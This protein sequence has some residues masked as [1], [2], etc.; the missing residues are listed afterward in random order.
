MQHPAIPDPSVLLRVFQIIAVAL[1]PAWYSISACY[2]SFS[3][4][5]PPTS[6][7]LRI[8]QLTL[9]SLGILSSVA[10]SVIAAKISDPYST[11]DPDLL[12]ALFHTLVWVIL[13]FGLIDA[14]STT[15]YPHCGAWAILLVSQSVILAC[16]AA[17]ISKSKNLLAS[18][19]IFQGIQLGLVGTLF[20]SAVILPFARHKQLNNG[21]DDDDEQQPLLA[22]ETDPSKPKKGDQDKE[23]DQEE[24]DRLKI[25][26]R[27]GWQY[28]ASFKLFV[29][30]M[31]P[32]S[33][34]QR[35]FLGGMIICSALTRIVTVGL[36]LSLGAVVNRLDREIPWAAIALY[37]FL[38]FLI[39]PAG[40]SLVESWFTYEVTTDMVIALNRHCYD[41]IM[42]LSADFH[43]SKRSSVIWQTMTQGQDVIDLLHDCVFQFLPTLI[44]LLSAAVVITYMFGPYLV[45]IIATTVVLFYWLTFK[46]LYKKRALQRSWLDAFYDQY[47]QLTEST[48]NWT[49]VCESGRVPYEMVRYREKCNATRTTIT[50]YW[51]YDCWTRGV[52]HAIPAVSFLAACGVAALQIRHHEHSIGDFVVL[53]M[54][55]AQL[56]DP[57]SVLAN[58]LS[59]VAHKLVHAEKLLVLLEKTPQIQ[60]AP[61][62]RPFTFL[63]GAVEFE[64]V[65]FS[66]DS[67]RKV[68]DNITFRAAPGK[69]VALV[70]QTG[71]GK[72]TILKLL[73]RFYD[74]DQGRILV[75]G[76]DIRHITMESLRGRIA[77]IP[78]SPVLFNM[79][80]LDN[81][82]YPNSN[83][84]DEEVIEA[85]KAA[86]LHE[87]IMTFT[88]GYQENVGERGTKLSGGELQRLAIARA[89]LKRPDILLL[90]EA[91]SSVDSITEKQIQTSLRE[92]CAGKTAFVIAHRLSTILH[93]DHILV[94]REGQIVESG[95]HEAL[96]RKKGVYN[97]LWC[98]Q[99]QMQ[100][101]SLPSRS[102]S[103]SPRKKEI[104]FLIN[105]MSTSGEESRVLIRHT[106]QESDTGAQ[107]REEHAEK[108][109]P[110]GIHYHDHTNHQ[111]SH[112]ANVTRSTITTKRLPRVLTRSISQR[113][114]S[115][116]STNSKLA[117]KPDAPE[118]VPHEFQARKSQ[119]QSLSACGVD[120]NE[121]GEKISP[122]S[123]SSSI[124]P[125][126]NASTLLNQDDFEHTEASQHDNSMHVEEEVDQPGASEKEEE[127]GEQKDSKL[128]L[129]ARRRQVAGDHDPVPQNDGVVDDGKNLSEDEN[130]FY[131]AR[132]SKLAHAASRRTKFAADRREGHPRDESSQDDMASQSPANTAA[133]S[134]DVLDQETN[135]TVP[136]NSPA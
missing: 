26:N 132:F 20:G 91:T 83:C 65:S 54:Y 79:S 31:S 108:S 118:F 130:S 71:G 42:N 27:P 107:E 35:T 70:G 114:S 3:T 103:Q 23:P 127:V 28:L 73:F 17:S 18:R 33:R 72:S 63:G 82:K 55:W 112:A 67:K 64:N 88:R 56:T 75:D 49:T 19:S 36:P 7:R 6:P 69:T 131:R 32:K 1:T 96:I 76:Q 25:R 111:V 104:P 125:H 43:D 77:M 100:D 80:I 11:N 113:K 12:Y 92:L 90:D 86:K 119:T 61:G 120:E 117:L 78:Q 29:P 135:L 62:A 53:I 74:V 109:K 9:T 30:F 123:I 106:T 46:V 89:I 87:K 129:F 134:P 38:R 39:S 115:P 93:A 121:G 110:S 51:F 128:P 37:G 16:Q 102:R 84:T 122:T 48:L 68:T 22:D 66:Y 95:V 101:A 59:K 58:E 97:E 50:L 98:S 116:K 52:R 15:S 2:A 99:L 41:H 47:Y 133:M 21:G 57:L 10:A 44:D 94:I 24:L 126:T 14:P 85:C 34:R 124:P 13:L 136:A 60:D 105:D 40:F 4:A 45:F 8:V 81:V 5:R